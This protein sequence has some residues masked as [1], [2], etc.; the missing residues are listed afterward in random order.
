MLLLAI[1]LLRRSMWE[2]VLWDRALS[3]VIANL[4]SPL[5]S[6]VTAL[7]LMALCT[8]EPTALTTDMYTMLAT[9]VDFPRCLDTQLDMESTMAT[10]SSATTFFLMGAVLSLVAV[11]LPAATLSIVGLSTMATYLITSELCMA[12]LLPFCLVLALLGAVLMSQLVVMLSW[13][14][15]LVWLL[16]PI[17]MTKLRAT[18]LPISPWTI[19]TMWIMMFITNILLTMM[20]ITSTLL[21]MTLNM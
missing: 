13:A 4:S 16:R 7:S 14:T 5:F 12:S 9:L 10:T 1:L 15:V 18:I 21:T 20:F 11:L 2:M 8:M 3:M 19:F 6:T 17:L